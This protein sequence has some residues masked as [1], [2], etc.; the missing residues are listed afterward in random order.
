MMASE[1][2]PSA[3]AE[4]RR[5]SMMVSSAWCAWCQAAKGQSAGQPLVC[6]LNTAFSFE[7]S[8]TQD[9]A[10]PGFR[11]FLVSGHPFDVGAKQP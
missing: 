2:G 8:R 7:A 5:Y 9:T 11:A 1:L 6:I 3:P 10:E 4:R